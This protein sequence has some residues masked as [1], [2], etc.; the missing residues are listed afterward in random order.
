MYV[1]MYVCNGRDVA[2]ITFSCV[3]RVSCV[4]NYIYVCI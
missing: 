3:A 2:I 1:Y 4:C